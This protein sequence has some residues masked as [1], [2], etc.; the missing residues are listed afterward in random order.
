MG[1]IIHY[2][3]KFKS[4]FFVI[5]IIFAVIFFSLKNK[6][7]TMPPP[8]VYLIP[9]EYFGPVFVFFGQEDGVDMQ[10]DPLGQAVLVPEN[11]IVKIKK[12][13]NLVLPKNKTE[14]QNVY[15][16]SISK[17][18][19]RKKF[20]FHENSMIDK[21]GNWYEIYYDENGMPHKNFT[22]KELFYYF[23]EKQKNEKIII[24]HGGCGRDNFIPEDDPIAKSPKCGMFLVIAP[25]SYRN[26]P[27][28]MW[29]DAHHSYSSIEQLVEESN[30]RLQK[31]KLFY[32]IP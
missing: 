26:L 11:G 32:N 20:I 30:E 27:K 19:A 10:D 5:S 7:S 21:D 14:Y 4:I 8:L 17:S 16:I 13:I 15:W 29:E 3:K 31:K 22:K 28:W 1:K 18:G 25:N 6:G 23:S 9:E 24:G 2:I 12:E